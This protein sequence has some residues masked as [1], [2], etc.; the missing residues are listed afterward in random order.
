MST[1]APEVRARPALD[2]EIP[3]NASL[4]ADLAVANGWVVRITYARGS[5]PIRD[6]FKTV[7]SIAVRMHREGA[8]VGVWHDGRFHGGLSRS[9]TYTLHE[10][11][12]MV[13]MTGHELREMVAAAAVLR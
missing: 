4:L 3:R 12:G 1:P 10:L 9:R 8:L 6:G 11:R 5:W 7:D 13:A 2:H